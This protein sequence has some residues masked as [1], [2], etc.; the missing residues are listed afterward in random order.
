MTGC[1]HGMWNALGTTALVV[2]AVAETV[3]TIHL[4]TEHD[5]HYHNLGCGHAHRYHEG[6]RVY[7][8]GGHWEYYDG[9]ENRWYFVE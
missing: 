8:Y 3:A 4:L 5:A 7:Q 1:T 6:R 9:V 2:G